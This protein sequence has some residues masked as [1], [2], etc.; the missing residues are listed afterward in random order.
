MSYTTIIH[1]ILADML[2]GGCSN[3]NKDEDLRSTMNFNDLHEP[4]EGHSSSEDIKKDVSNV[5]ENVKCHQAEHE[6][7]YKDE[8]NGSR[9]SRKMISSVPIKSLT[10]P[11]SMNITPT[12][13]MTKITGRLLRRR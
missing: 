8:A 5:G 10:I 2:V 1:Y 4:I 12:E 11:L 13:A 6:C 9:R 7:L 3:C